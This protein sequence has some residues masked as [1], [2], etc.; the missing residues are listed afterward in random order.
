MS[1]L[2][3]IKKNIARNRAK[4][5][6]LQNKRQSFKLEQLEPRLLLSGA[7]DD[8]QCAAIMKTLSNYSVPV[9]PGMTMADVVNLEA[10]AKGE[11]SGADFIKDHIGSVTG[12]TADLDLS[13]FTEQIKI[14][15][16]FGPFN[17]KGPSTIEIIG[18]TS[19]GG[20]ISFDYTTGA[21]LIP[22]SNATHLFIPSLSRE[23]KPEG[24]GEF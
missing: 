4:A 17:P 5:L 10:A 2:K 23:G 24:R 9:L 14:L 21:N 6:A 16:N 13:G 3:T 12:T 18:A 15:G 8:G 19:T 11:P 20:H 22:R 1:I 7:P